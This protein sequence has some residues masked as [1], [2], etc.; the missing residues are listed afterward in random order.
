MEPR[1]SEASG[2]GDRR[3]GEATFTRNRGRLLARVD[4]GLGKPRLLIRL[5]VCQQF[6]AVRFE[7]GEH[8]LVG[9]G[10]GAAELFFLLQGKRSTAGTSQRRK[11]YQASSAGPVSRARPRKA[12]AGDT[13]AGASVL[14][15]PPCRCRHASSRS[16]PGGQ[17]WTALSNIATKKIYQG[18]RP[19]DPQGKD[20]T[21]HGVSVRAIRNPRP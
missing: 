2:D 8:R 16:R 20:V 19:L 7:A 13:P 3:I 4:V 6:G 12:P 9:T 11:P 14:T 17:R 21:I 18:L 5:S 10:A 1:R 15:G